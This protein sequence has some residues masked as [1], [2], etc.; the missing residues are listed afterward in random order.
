MENQIVN[1]T[2]HVWICCSHLGYARGKCHLKGGESSLNYKQSA[3][4]WCDFFCVSSS[5]ALNN[6]KLF[7][8][9]SISSNGPKHCP[10]PVSWKDPLIWIYHIC[11]PSFS[12]EVAETQTVQGF[13]PPYSLLNATCLWLH[14]P[15]QE[16]M[17]S[18]DYQH[19]SH[20]R[21]RKCELEVCL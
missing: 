21:C 13:P 19:K 1:L 16:T 6:T 7:C 17:C 9:P 8:L 11:S 14:L 5:V 12:S 3:I 10:D 15:A 20:M 18:I 2:F 4:S